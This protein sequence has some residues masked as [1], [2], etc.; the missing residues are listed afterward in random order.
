MIIAYRRPMNIGNVLSYRNLNTNPTA[1]ARLVIL[2][3]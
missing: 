3:V 1:P 2:P